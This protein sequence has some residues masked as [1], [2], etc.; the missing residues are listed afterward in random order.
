MTEPKDKREDDQ[1]ESRW[2]CPNPDCNASAMNY[3]PVRC[4]KCALY[5]GG[6]GDGSGD[7]WDEERWQSYYANGWEW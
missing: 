6:D 2:Y 3:V 7:D 4:H 5:V 1:I